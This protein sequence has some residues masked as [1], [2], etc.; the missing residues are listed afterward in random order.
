MLRYVFNILARILTG[1]GC[2]LVL[3]SCYAKDSESQLEEL[4]IIKEDGE[5]LSYRI[6][7]ADT[8]AT[9]KKGLMYRKYMPREQGMLLVYSRSRQVNIW[10]KNTH[11]PLDIIYIDER[12]EIT[13]ITR[14]AVPFSLASMPSQSKVLAV[15]E[16]NAG[17]T[18]KQEIQVGDQVVHP[19]FKK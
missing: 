1:C 8:A 2:V 16:L 12:G 17:E 14:D 13:Q 15:L 4:L 7:I 3:S 5:V 11:I 10:M 6:E 18:E 9:R 19:V